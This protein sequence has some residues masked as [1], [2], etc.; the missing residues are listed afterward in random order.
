MFLAAA[1]IIPT[2]K[3]ETACAFLPLTLNTRIPLFVASSTLTFSTPALQTP[4]ILRFGI[5]SIT[6]LEIGTNNPIKTSASLPSL[7]IVSSTV[8]ISGPCFSTSNLLY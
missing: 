4:A 5:A 6:L 2:A 8:S 7:R 1:N 3:S